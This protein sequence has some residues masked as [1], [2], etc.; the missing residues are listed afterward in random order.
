MHKWYAGD[1]GGAQRSLERARGLDDSVVETWTQ[2]GRT[3]A[4]RGAMAGASQL[5]REAIEKFPESIALR[6]A[7]V[8]MYR[9]G[10]ELSRA[11]DEAK[12]ALKVRADSIEL[13]NSMGLSYMDMGSLGL[14]RFV[15][16]KAMSAVSGAEENAYL[17]CNL[18]RVYQLEGETALARAFYDKKG[19]M[20]VRRKRTTPAKKWTWAW[21]NR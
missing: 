8:E 2:L 12:S 18:G 14:A 10:G 21:W 16:Q 1:L 19:M 17:A 11:V 7:L 3:M 13:Y 9:Q 6:V 20:V 15:F 5:F 4:A